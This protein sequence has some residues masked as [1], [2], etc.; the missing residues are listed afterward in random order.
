[1]KL[2]GSAEFVE[3]PAALPAFQSTYGFKLSADQIVVLAGG[4]T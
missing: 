2:A 1:M 3:S 4:D